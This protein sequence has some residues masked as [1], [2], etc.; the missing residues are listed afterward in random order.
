MNKKERLILVTNDD[1]YRSKGIRELAKLAKEFGEVVIVAPKEVESGTS[2]SVTLRK[3]LYVNEIQD[4]Y[5]CTGKPADCVKIAIHKLI[6]RKPDLVLSG[7]N[8]GSNSSVSSIYS[9]TIGA[10]R[11]ASLNGIPSIG[12]SLLDYM[13]DADFDASVHFARKIIKAALENEFTGNY[14]LNVNIPKLKLEEIQGIKVCRQTIG[15]WEEEF[16]YKLDENNIGAYWLKGQFKNF[17]PDANDTDEWALNNNYVAVVPINTDSTNY[18]V[19]D[20]ML[21]WKF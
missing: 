15:K 8:H 5:Y 14:C 11:E 1:G 9:G 4:G 16:E 18:K 12:F 21:N 17:E 3:P 7:I 13:E 20:K 19:F 6:N 2:H 10:A